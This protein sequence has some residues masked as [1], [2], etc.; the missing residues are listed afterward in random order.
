MLFIQ[1]NHN[2]YNRTLR[3]KQG[4]EEFGGQLSLKNRYQR[5]KLIHKQHVIDK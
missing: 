1:T 3:R 5:Y 4:G 2:C